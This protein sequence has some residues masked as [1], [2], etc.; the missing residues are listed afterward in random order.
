M[1]GGEQQIYVESSILSSNEKLI[2]GSNILVNTNIILLGQKSSDIVDVIIEYSILNEQGN[3]LYEILIETKGILL[4]T[5][6]LK[7]ITL[8]SNIEPGIYTLNVKASYNGASKTT[9]NTFE[10]VKIDS[11]LLSGKE[12][13]ISIIFLIIFIFIIFGFYYSY[14]KFKHLEKLISIPKFKGF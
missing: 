9:S 12:Q 11:Y 14:R 3:P 1:G 6:I 2:A 8:P 10:V 5:D 7:E 4:R 13:I